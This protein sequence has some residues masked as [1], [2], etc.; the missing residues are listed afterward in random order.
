VI[1]QATAYLNVE[2]IIK[3]VPLEE[4]VPEGMRLA[5]LFEP[6][7]IIPTVIRKIDLIEHH[8][9]LNSLEE[10]DD[11]CKRT[12]ESAGKIISG[13]DISTERYCNI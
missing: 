7:L 4:S 12:G 11:D 8:V 6:Y 2:E 10:A 5:T 9:I 1:C 13:R 3:N